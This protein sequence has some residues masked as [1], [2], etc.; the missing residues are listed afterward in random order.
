MS[1]K[2][3]EFKQRTAC[4]LPKEKRALELM[5][6][7]CKRQGNWYTIG[8][9]WKKDKALLPNNYLLAERRLFSLERN[10]LKDNAKAK[11][12]DEAIM[13]YKTNG[14]ARP[15]SKQEEQAD[16]NPVYYLPHHGIY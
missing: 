12:Y 3:S 5:E 9:P 10:L 8:L 16:V 1:L 11:M 14:W 2:L 13:E 6:T 15:L 4:V 7:S